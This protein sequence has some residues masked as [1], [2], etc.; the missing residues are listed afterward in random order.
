MI[1]ADPSTTAGPL[2]GIK[3]DDAEAFILVLAQA[4]HAHGASAHRLEGMLTLVARRL[5]IEARFYSTPTA[6][7]ASFGPLAAERTCLVRVEPG[8]VNLEKMSLLYKITVKVI[9][10]KVTADEGRAHVAAVVSAPPRYRWP[11]VIAAYAFSSG[12]AAMFFGGGVREIAV[13][14][15]AGLVVGVIARATARFAGGASLLEPLAAAVVAVVAQLAARAAGPMSTLVITVAGVYTLLP[16]LGIT[17]AMNELATRNLSSGTA[18][19]AGALV[20]FVG[21]GFGAALGAR[22]VAIL[23]LPLPPLPSPPPPSTTWSLGALAA[24]VVV[25]SIASSVLLQARPRDVGWIVVAGA[26]AFGGARLG[27]HFLG[28]ELGAFVGAF[29]LVLASNAFAHR[30]DRPSAV[31]MVPSLLL[32]VPGSI[33]FRSLFSMIESDVVSGIDAAFKMVLV[34]T[35]LVAGAVV[36]SIALPT[37]RAL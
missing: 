24:A 3:P 29:L 18:R 5:G 6:V 17:T 8:A 9:R 33:G 14:L 21:L 35:A 37:R 10:G 32:L 26:I 2:P 19:F 16:G 15:G 20:Q 12:T 30:F 7:L 22:L 27:A 23:P 4:L 1:I 34:A 31:P 25:S 11:S 13:V 36:A 28:P